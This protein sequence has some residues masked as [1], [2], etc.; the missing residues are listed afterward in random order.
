MNAAHTPSVGQDHAVGSDALP[1]LRAGIIGIGNMGFAI[2][3]RLLDTGWPVSVRDIDTAREAAARS[4]GATVCSTPGLL[5]GQSDCV[6]VCVVDAAQVEAVLFDADGGVCSQPSRP[7]VML[8]PTVAPGDAA[9]IALRLEAHGFDCIEA[10][11]SGGPVR[12]RSGSM[13]LMVACA[14]AAFERHAEL[15]ATLADP[16]FRIGVRIGDGARTKLVNNLLAAINLAGAAEALALAQRVG[17]DP[18]RTLDVVER[19]SGQSWI[20]TE[21]MRRALAGDLEPRAHTALLNKDA[22]LALAM[23][24]EAGFDAQVG[25]RASALF[26][27]ACASGLDRLDDASLLEFLSNPAASSQGPHPTGA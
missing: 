10:P 27:R 26:A 3:A 15:L 9:A 23:A 20:G 22:R 19:S 12:A 21:R 1:V 2:A 5:A 25:A 13:S 18:A 14:D 16:V 24:V 17:L 8:C 4:L 7:S 11:M 6:I